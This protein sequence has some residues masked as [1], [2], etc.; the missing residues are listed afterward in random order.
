ML[1][2]HAINSTMGFPHTFAEYTSMDIAL[3]QVGFFRTLLS[4]PSCST[5]VTSPDMLSP[6]LREL[7]TIKCVLKF[8]MFSSTCLSTVR[9]RVLYDAVLSAVPRSAD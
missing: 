9:I 2:I 8:G 4:T 5:N 6:A 7:D 1:C 3:Y